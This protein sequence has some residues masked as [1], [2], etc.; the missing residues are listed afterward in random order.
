MNLQYHATVD[1]PIRQPNRQLMRQCAA[2]ASLAGARGSVKQ[3]YAIPTH[4]VWR[5][6]L[7]TKEQ[8]RGGILE[9]GGLGHRGQDET[10]P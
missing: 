3:N 5:N 1:E 9:K 10:V 6:Q 7:I 2:K 8:C 4:N